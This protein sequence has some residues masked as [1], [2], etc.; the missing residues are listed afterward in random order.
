MPIRND[1]GMKIFPELIIPDY[2][3]MFDESLEIE[4]LNTSNFSDKNQ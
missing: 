2:D 1:S 4:E 3:E